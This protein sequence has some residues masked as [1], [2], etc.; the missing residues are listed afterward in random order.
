MSLRTQLL[1]FGLLTLVL[2]WAGLRFVQEMEAAL[3]RGL[4]ASLLASAGT[5][6]AALDDAPAL[7][8]PVGERA[9]DHADVATTIYAEPLRRELTVDGFPNDWGPGDTTVRSLPGGHD[10]RVGVYGRYAYLFVAVSDGDIVY[11]G[12]PGQTPYGDRLVLV[13]EPEAGAPRSLLLMTR[14]PGRFRAQRTAP[15][16][17]APSGSFEDRILSAWRTTPAGFTVELR[18]PLELIGSSLG[19]AVIDVDPAGPADYAVE[20]NSTWEGGQASPSP[21]VHQLPNLQEFVTRFSRAGDR[22]RVVNRAGW[23]LS[24]AGGVEPGDGVADAAAT[25]VS[26]RFFR[27]LLRR[28]DPQY[29]TLEQPFG[30]LGDA[31]LRA[32]LGGELATAWFRRGPEDSAI[33]AAAV[34]IR[35]PEGVL[36][37]VLLEQ[38]S[39]PI[40]TLTNQALMRLMTFTVLASVLAA[41]GLLGYATLLSVRVRRLANA[42]ETALGPKGE[43]QLAVPGRRAR[44][45]LGDLARS[46]ADLLRRLREHTDYLRTLTSKLS[47]ELR[48]PLAVV[49]TSLDNLE[50][51]VGKDSARVYLRRL[52]DGAGRLDSILGAMSEATQMEHAIAETTPEVFDLARVVEACCTAYRDVYRERSF[53]F[54]TSFDGAA[55]VSGSAELV[56]QLMDKLIDNAVGFSPAGSRI[57]VLL[58]GTSAE[59]VLS[60]SNEGSTLPES[61]REQLFDSLVS[62]RKHGDGRPH[63]GLGLYVVALIA[64]FHAG[65]VEAD[66]LPGERGVVFRVR[67]PRHA[68]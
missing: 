49:S 59:L 4:E 41:L 37:A 62:L 1:A 36:G 12:S 50:H 19:L 31:T 25:T 16:A 3:R 27:A 65:R 14:A 54:E 33:V 57:G 38:A 28:D 20:L 23:V 15:P 42:A 63:L 8:R 29:A 34:P 43:I 6:A 39:D 26:E 40:L 48:T 10:Y 2:P 47:H 22:F 68:G 51:E 32:A 13:L 67:F 46:F 18:V 66:N 11:Q 5:V 35:G 17:F 60:V 61:M 24:D 7:I 44:D 21:L 55:T 58:A 52:R 30:Y 9:D 45:E 56:A 53:D 64:K